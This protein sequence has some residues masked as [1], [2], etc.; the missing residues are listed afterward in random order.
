MKTTFWSTIL[1]FSLTAFSTINAQDC[2]KGDENAPRLFSLYKEYYKQGNIEKALPYW[3]DVYNSAPGFGKTIFIDGVEIYEHLIANEEDE[4]TKQK[5]VDTLLSIY[6]NRIKCWGDEAYVLQLKGIS[7]AQY[8]PADYPKA[9]EILKEAIDLAGKDAKYYGVATYFNLLINVMN[10]VEGI[11]ADFV[12]NEYTKLVDICDANIE[13]DNLGEQFAD[14]KAGMA[15]NLKEYVLPKRFADGA[16]WYSWTPEEK[17]DS[18]RMWVSQD[19]SLTNIE[20]ILSNIR[21]DADVKDSNIRYELE[22]ILFENNP[23]ASRANNIG[24][25]FYENKDFET[26]ITFFKKA[27]ELTEDSSKLAGAYLALADTYRQADDFPNARAAAQEAMAVDSNSAQPY[28]LI[29]VLYLSS[30]SKCGPGTGFNSQRVL[31][32]AYDYFKKAIELDASFEEIVGPLMRD[33]K[34]F[35]PTRAEVAERGL[36]VGGKYTVPC[37]INEEA[38]VLVRD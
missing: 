26:A 6:D 5:Y 14:V 38:T 27:V 24:A 31:W 35:L 21:R 7:I 36:R 11:D 23:T 13:A 33:Y 10:E 30:G 29:G 32:P 18:V 15:Y 25:H 34:K 17:E 3:R 1:V 19:S 4:V 2:P 16:D 12:K 20:D 9:V 22:Q 37:W 28:Y 8:R